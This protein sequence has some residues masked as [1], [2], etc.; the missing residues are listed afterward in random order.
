MNDCQAQINIDA[1]T[2]TKM[3]D[4]GKCQIRQNKNASSDGELSSAR[5]AGAGHWSQ[6]IF[7][8]QRT[9]SR[10]LHLQV[11]ASEAGSCN[12]GGLMLTKARACSSCTREACM[13]LLPFDKEFWS[14]EH[15]YLLCCCACKRVS[16]IS[17]F[18]KLT[19][20]WCR[21]SKLFTFKRRLP[22]VS[23]AL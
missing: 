15:L 9:F 13:Y 6:L 10:Q 7:R 5:A 8:L 21:S 14:S 2:P 3:V 20:V 12:S 18:Q 19:I 4:R 16:T 1:V 11:R 17:C 23:L 22:M